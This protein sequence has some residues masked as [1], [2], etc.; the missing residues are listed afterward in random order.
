MSANTRTYPRRSVS[1]CWTTISG[2]RKQRGNAIEIADVQDVEDA[3]RPP[4]RHIASIRYARKTEEFSSL[5][6]LVWSCGRCCRTKLGERRPRRRRGSGGLAR[7]LKSKALNRSVM[8]GRRKTSISLQAAFWAG[9]KEIADA[10]DVPDSA[11]VRRIDTD[12]RHANL[13]SALRLYVLDHYRRLAETKA[14]R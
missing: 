11:L 13:T 4:K 8:L 3:S 10:E 6:P 12:R 14:K 9:L 5:T 2:W 1:W 7:R